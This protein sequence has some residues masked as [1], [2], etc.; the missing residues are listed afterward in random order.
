EA[1]FKN[2]I[3]RKETI[4][5]R[6]KNG[7][8]NC[9]WGDEQPL[10]GTI[11]AIN[12]RD[13]ANKG[14]FREDVPFVVVTLTDEDELSTGPSKATKPQEVINAV[15]AAFGS[16]K[17]FAAYGIIILPGD[18]ACLKY[19][20]GQIKEKYGAAYGTHVADLA[21]LTEGS[22]SSICENDYAGNLSDISSKVR[23]LM[24]TFRLNVEPI[25]SSVQV[26]LT[27]AQPG[28]TFKV[29]GKKIIFS[30]PPAAGTRID[31]SYIP[32]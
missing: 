27:P 14:F 16:E 13:R 4:G 18:A 31:V 7:G 8:Y 6:Q 15:T 5:C 17:K 9:P 24:G 10:K 11:L 19:Q 20:N 22:V 25:P 1:A 2:S 32:K 26:T 21:Q 23:R 3:V 29:E 28:I 12:E 30:S